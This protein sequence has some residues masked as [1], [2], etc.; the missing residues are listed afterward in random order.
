MEK[1]SQKA[2]CQQEDF[3]LRDRDYRRVKMKGF[4]DEMLILAAREAVLKPIS[5]TAYC[6]KKYDEVLT[7]QDYNTG[8]SEI[9]REVDKME[10]GMYKSCAYHVI[11]YMF[12]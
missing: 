3:R 12:N 8:N 5:K 9:F 6:I 11:L 1:E 10:R 4:A 7:D 2:E